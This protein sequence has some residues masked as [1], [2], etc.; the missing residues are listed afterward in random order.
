MMALF[1]CSYFTDK[2]RITVAMAWKLIRAREA[3]NTNLE[4]YAHVNFNGF[5]NKY[6]FMHIFSLK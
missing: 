6:A 5:L 2:Q 3:H 4:Y 1:D